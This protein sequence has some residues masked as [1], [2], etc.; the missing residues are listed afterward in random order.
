MIKLPTT[1]GRR[2]IE[3]ENLRL[4]LRP[5]ISIH[6]KPHLTMDQVDAIRDT[7][8]HHRFL[9]QMETLGE[10]LERGEFDVELRALPV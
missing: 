3:L 4:A 9:D 6:L 2:Q 5:E 7:V 8:D 10:A 1:P